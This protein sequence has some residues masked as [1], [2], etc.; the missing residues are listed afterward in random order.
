MFGL[1]A[2]MAM[3]LGAAPL[4]ASDSVAHRCTVV[5]LM[6]S[7][8]EYWATHGNAAPVAARRSFVNDFVNRYPDLYST[9]VLHNGSPIDAQVDSFLRASPMTCPASIQ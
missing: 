8:R 1:T 3:A 2:I 9:N 7:F 4:N 5:N 6:P